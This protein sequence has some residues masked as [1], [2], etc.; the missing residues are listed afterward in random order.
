ME[1]EKPNFCTTRANGPDEGIRVWGIMGQSFSVLFRNIVPF[2]VLAWAVGHTEGL[3][4]AANRSLIASLDLSST[5]VLVQG[6]IVSFVVRAFSNVPVEAVIAMAVCLDLGGRRLTLKGSLMS[7]VRSIP[8]ILHRPLYGFVATVFTVS[9]LR[10]AIISPFY[11]AMVVF[12]SGWNSS[13]S[14]ALGLFFLAIIPPTLVDTR[15]LTLFPVAAVER[16]GVVHSFRRCWRLSSDHWPRI[17]GVVLLVLLLSSTI[18][19]SRTLLPFWWPIDW[20]RLPSER[21]LPSLFAALARHLLWNLTG[22]LKPLVRSYQA[23]VAAVCYHHLLVANGEKAGE[24]T[25]TSST[26]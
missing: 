1:P 18:T 13:L 15:L 25:T 26:G 10:A 3:L 9:F 11:V 6:I 20:F 21:S 7:T 23:V 16:R 5:L 19:A 22:L 12:A 17:L 24:E 2:L 14:R 8:G 4:L